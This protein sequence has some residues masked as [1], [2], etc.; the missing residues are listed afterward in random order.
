MKHVFMKVIKITSF[1]L[2][3]ATFSERD[4]IARNIRFSNWKLKI[5][6]SKKDVLKTLCFPIEMKLVLMISMEFISFPLSGQVFPERDFT[7][8][9][10]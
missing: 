5:L 1:L 8:Q 3:N 9:N 4:F 2:E 6:K 10:L 7:L